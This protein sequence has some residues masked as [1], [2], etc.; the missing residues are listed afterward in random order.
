MASKSPCKET[1]DGDNSNPER[2]SEQQEKCGTDLW[3]LLAQG[4]HQP[5]YH[6]ENN[7]E[8]DLI[9]TVLL[10]EVIIG[11]L[12]GMWTSIHC[13]DYYIHTECILGP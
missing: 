12:L 6:V 2:A 7:N 1:T 8:W 13:F 10:I 11:N 3:L 5:L 9:H 4:L